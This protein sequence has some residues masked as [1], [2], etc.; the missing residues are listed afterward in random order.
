[1]QRPARVGVHVELGN[2]P[3]ALLYRRPQ[4]VQRVSI[5]PTQG[6]PTRR[7]H[8]KGRVGQL[9]GVKSSRGLYSQDNVAAWDP[10]L[11]ACKRTYEAQLSAPSTNSG[12]Q[13]DRRELPFGWLAFPLAAFTVLS[14]SP[15]RLR[16]R[17]EG[18][19]YQ[20]ALE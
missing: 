6:S 1:M 5:R 3:V 10:S 16:T 18:R 19:R 14:A 20:R 15:G 9:Q 11:G 4:A 7:P 17:E 13:D 12:C 2:P 8:E